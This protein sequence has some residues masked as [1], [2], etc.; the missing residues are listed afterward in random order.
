MRSSKPAMQCLFAQEGN[1]L[2]DVGTAS[3]A[4]PVPHAQTILVHRACT[5]GGLLI[6]LAGL[7]LKANRLLRSGLPLSF[8]LAA[9]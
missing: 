4:S 6:L 9:P 5:L 1:E 2:Y 7:A 8:C 3:H